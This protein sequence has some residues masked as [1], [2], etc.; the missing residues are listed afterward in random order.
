M[1]ASLRLALETHRE[2]LLRGML[3]PQVHEDAPATGPPGRRHPRGAG[4][5]PRPGPWSSCWRPPALPRDRRA[6]SAAW[7]TTS[8]TPA[9]PRVSETTATSATPTSPPSARSAGRSSPGLLRPRRR[10]PGPGRLSPPSPPPWP[11]GRSTRTQLARSLRRGGRSART[12][13]PSTT[14]RCPSPSAPCPTPARSTTSSASGWP[15]GAGPAATWAA[16][17]TATASKPSD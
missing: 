17:P 10:R 14:A 8:W 3:A 4:S 5:T 13:P 9:F 16:R 1:P 7:P 12:R 6:R 2:P 11:D 15:S